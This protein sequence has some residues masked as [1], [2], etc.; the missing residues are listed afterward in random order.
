MNAPP[1]S[2]TINFAYVGEDSIVK[3][4][5]CLPSYTPTKE[6]IEYLTAVHAHEEEYNVPGGAWYRQDLTDPKRKAAGIGAT[7]N[8]ELDAFIPICSFPSWTLNK[9]TY[10]W[11]P[12][13]PQ[14][15]PFHAW[16]EKT[17]S[18]VKI[19]PDV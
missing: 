12:P 6:G 15:S 10:E 11:T 18:W 17:Q 5:A 2:Q 16:D 1:I 7:Y 14:P 9:E 4:V 19:Y 8:A 3:N 13:S